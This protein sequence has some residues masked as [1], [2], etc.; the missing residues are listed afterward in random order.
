MGKN[1]FLTT[2]THAYINLVTSTFPFSLG[3]ATLAKLKRCPSWYWLSSLFVYLHPCSYSW[4]EL[5][6]GLFLNGFLKENKTGE[7]KGKHTRVNLEVGHSITRLFRDGH[8]SA[9]FLWAPLCP[10]CPAAPPW[11]F[12]AHHQ[13]VIPTFQQAYAYPATAAEPL[14]PTGYSQED[15]RSICKCLIFIL[16]LHIVCSQTIVT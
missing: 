2:Y 10:E 9:A 13:A 7:L 5:G 11:Q 1:Q 8:S 14:M 6:Q 4:S 12:Q 16:A 3:S 15:F